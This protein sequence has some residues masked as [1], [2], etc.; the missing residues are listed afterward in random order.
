LEVKVFRCLHTETL[1][2]LNATRIGLKLICIGDEAAT[3]GFNPEI[4]FTRPKI[5]M[6]GDD[7][8]HF[9]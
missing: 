3:E 9:I 7:C 2:K 4:K 8:C 1:K 6:A 5:L